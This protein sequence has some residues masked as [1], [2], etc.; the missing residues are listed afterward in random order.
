MFAEMLPG[1]PV[2]MAMVALACGTVG[3]DDVTT[4]PPQSLPAQPSTTAVSAIEQVGNVTSWDRLPGGLQLQCGNRQRVRID[5]LTERLFRVRF[6]ADGSFPESFLHEPWHLVKSNDG[7]PGAPFDVREENQELHVI[8]ARLRLQLKKAPL[9]V[10][11]YD[12]D[13]RLLTREGDRPGMGLGP[14]AGLRM[15]RAPEEHFFGLGEGLGSTRPEAGFVTK[16]ILDMPLHGTQL[17]GGSIT[18]DQTG[19]KALL[20]LGP[21]WAGFTMAPVV[22]PFFMSTQGYGIYLNAFRESIFDLACTDTNAWS[23][24]L[25]GPPTM[26]LLPVCSTITSSMAPPSNRSST[27][28][29]T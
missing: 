24:A 18:L 8:M 23:I 10:S 17:E 12:R 15:D 22:I 27:P 6:S 13:N 16:T 21:N 2:A 19:K 4:A 1:S 29:P 11:V 28:T 20:F 26:C 25:G 7:F 3:A 5:I 14:G 9:R